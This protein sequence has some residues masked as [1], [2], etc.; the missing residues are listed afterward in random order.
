MSRRRALAVTLLLLAA[1]VAI[2]AVRVVDGDRAL[3]SHVE[4]R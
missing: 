2:E 4:R 1:A 3:L